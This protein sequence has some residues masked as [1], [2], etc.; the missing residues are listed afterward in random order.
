MGTVV[1]PGVSHLAL[2][3]ATTALALNEGRGGDF[4]I[5]LGD[6]LFE[7]PFTVTS[8]PAADDPINNKELDETSEERTLGTVCCRANS[9]AKPFGAIPKGVAPTL[10]AF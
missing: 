1:L 8:A 6:V 7:R 10:A 2:F 5:K 3:A 9:V 4:H